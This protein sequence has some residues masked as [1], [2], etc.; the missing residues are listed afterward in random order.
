MGVC[1]GSAKKNNDKLSIRSST[2]TEYS[3]LSYVDYKKFSDPLVR[4][5][6]FFPFNRINVRIFY[7]LIM[8]EEK[9]LYK[10]GDLESLLTTNAWKN[11]FN[12]N[13][14]LCNMLNDMPK[15]RDEHFDRLSLLCLGLLW[16]N[17]SIEDKAD[18][19]GKI[20]NP[21][22][23]EFEVICASDRDMEPAIHRIIETATRFTLKAAQNCKEKNASSF[24]PKSC[25]GIKD[26][27]E[28]KFDEPENQDL[29]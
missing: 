21:P 24:D 29:I 19:F 8:L 23:Q 16:C 28:L 3:D 20:V 15:S 13:T 14:P 11:Q 7:N 4:F 6:N 9:E 22:G 10:R 5:Q 1:C 17:G 27:L 25:K 12:L 2:N 18:V 26:L